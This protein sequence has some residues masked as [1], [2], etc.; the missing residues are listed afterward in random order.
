MALR[1]IMHGL[2]G[3]LSENTPEE[4]TREFGMYLME[5]EKVVVG[6]RLIRDVVIFTDRRIL[7]LDKQGTTG[8]KMRIDSIYLASLI[9]VT[10]E[11]AGMGIDDSEITV[12]YI[13]SP[14]F[15][16]SG[17]VET[18]QKKFEFPR[19]YDIRPLYRQ[20]TEIAYENFTRLNG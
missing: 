12:T 15:R 4:L 13:T 11:T 1:D 7:D 16:A 9:G 5:G 19:K 10:A 20:L 18:E 14:Y 2:A 3:N 8:K 6:F 17:G